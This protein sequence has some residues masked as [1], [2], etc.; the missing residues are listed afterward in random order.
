MKCSIISWIVHSFI[1]QCQI[2]QLF[3]ALF[4]S[5]MNSS[6]LFGLT[7][8]QSFYEKYVFLNHFIVVHIDG[9]SEQMDHSI[10]FLII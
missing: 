9:A 10:V 7:G 6:Q 1:K 3:Y 2:I 4:N 8:I 5:S